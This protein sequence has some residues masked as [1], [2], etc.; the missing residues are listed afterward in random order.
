MTLNIGDI[1]A[2]MAAICWSSGVILFEISGRTLNSIQ[3]NF[4]KNII[5]LIGFVFVLLFTGSLCISY[6]SHEYWLLGFSALLGVALGDLFLLAGL[7]RLGSGMYAIAGTTYSLFVFLFAFLMFQET[8][9]FQVYIGGVLVILGIVV[10]SSTDVKSQKNSQFS[11]GITYVILAQGL[12]AYSVL[13]VRPVMEVHPVIHI[14]MI[15]FGIGVL[16]NIGHILL[17]DGMRSLLKTIKTGFTNP[18]MV[19]GSFLGTFLAVIFWMSGFKYTLAGR[20]A[21]YNQ[22]STIFITLLA[23]IFLKE[24]MNVKSWISVCLAVVGAIL[25]STS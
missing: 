3:I 20:A 4:L 2:L 21:I 5:G 17:L 19:L 16:F 9:A 7:K 23:A 6:T 24:K 15:R 14:A 18:A 11:K 25:V 10:R 22:L 12:T 1:Y 13:L 8:I